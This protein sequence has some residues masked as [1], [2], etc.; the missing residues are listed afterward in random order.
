MHETA[1]K[2]NQQEQLPSLTRSTS[3]IEQILEPSLANSDIPYEIRMDKSFVE[4]IKTRQK[5]IDAY[6]A[7]KIDRGDTQNTN[8]L[9]EELSVFFNTHTEFARAALYIPFTLLPDVSTNQSKEALDFVVSFKKAFDNLL[10]HIDFRAD[11]MDGD[12]LE[13]GLRA[14]KLPEQVVKAPHLLPWLMNKGIF[15]QQEIIAYI[16]GATTPHLV[17]ALADVVPLLYRESLVDDALLGVLA[18]SPHQQFRDLVPRLQ[19]THHTSF[20]SSLPLHTPKQIIASFMQSH[21]AMMRRIS[22]DSISEG[23]KYWQQ[24]VQG[25]HMQDEFALKL[26]PHIQNDM[27]T[28]TI[29][30]LL[31]G[32]NPHV[33][34]LLITSLRIKAGTEFEIEGAVNNHTKTLITHTLSKVSQKNDRI[35][36]QAYDKLRAYAHHYGV[37]IPAP[38]N[39]QFTQQKDTS[40]TESYFETLTS[41]ARYIEEDQVLSHC[42]YPV[43]ISLGSHAKGYAKEGSDIDMGIFVREGTQEDERKAIHEKLA[44]MSRHLGI[45][46]SS[47]EFWLEKNEDG[48]SIKNYDNPDPRRG[49]SSLTHPLTGQWVGNLGATKSLRQNLMRMYL[50]NTN[51]TI[52]GHNARSVWLKD[53]EHNMVQYRLMHKG[54]A[55]HLPPEAIHRKVSHFSIDSESMFYDNGY[56]TV[57]FDIYLKKVFLPEL[58]VE[59]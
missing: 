36:T 55:S 2:Q 44:E 26:A 10:T 59:K 13:P 22:A 49:D 54:Y 30:A 7:Y 9:Y 16:E 50:N 58:S 33:T 19:K 43:V 8:K 52:E 18:T 57:A 1:P 21:E 29:D 48:V 14:G 34:S 5:T 39:P 41:C 17:Q 25:D 11:F 40:R 38:E 20:E 51:K 28:S 56:R 4:Q 32:N 45:H 24:E 27:D 37:A 53:L 3:F 35:V 23:R 47:M 42:L 12:I 6:T 15:S 31:G 46:G